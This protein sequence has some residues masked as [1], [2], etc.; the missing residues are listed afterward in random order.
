MYGIK[1]VD[2]DV[3]GSTIFP[4]TRFIT[5]WLLSGHKI[6]HSNNIINKPKHANIGICFRYWNLSGLKV[7]I[8][9]TDISFNLFLQPKYKIDK[10]WQRFLSHQV[11]WLYG[12]NGIILL[13]SLFLPLHYVIRTCVHYKSWAFFFFALLVNKMD[14]RE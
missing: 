11:N 2:I 13:S 1:W 6:H 3:W 7:D 10:T 8:V 12:G 14:A 9:V 5:E 4:S